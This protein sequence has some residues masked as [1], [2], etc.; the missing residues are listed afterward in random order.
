MPSLLFGMKRLLKKELSIIE[1]FFA[2]LKVPSG[3]VENRRDQACIKHMYSG[4][5]QEVGTYKFEFL[6][7]LSFLQTSLKLRHR[8]I[9]A[10][11]LAA[12][13]KN[14]VGHHFPDPVELP[15]RRTLKHLW[16]A[17]SLRFVLC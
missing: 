6:E 8:K 9:I 1:S 10:V 3:Q 12:L 17:K 11:H 5:V 16:Q 4:N 7:I 2:L 13:C 15:H 14:Y